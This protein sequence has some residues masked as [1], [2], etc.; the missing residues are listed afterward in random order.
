[1]IKRA[2]NFYRTLMA[3]FPSCSIHTFVVVPYNNRMQQP[4]RGHRFVLGLAP[5]A[6]FPHTQATSPRPAAD[7]G[8]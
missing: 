2:S 3:W 7:A 4:G 8:R 6:G 5:P 1:M